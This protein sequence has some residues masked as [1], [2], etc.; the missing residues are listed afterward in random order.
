M[1][2]AIDGIA[3]NGGNTV[4]FYNRAD[5]DSAASG[6]IVVLA[7][8]YPAVAD[9]IATR[10][11]QL[12]DKII[13]DITNPLNFETFDSLVV[14][15]TVQLRRRERKCGRAT[16]RA[17]GTIRYGISLASRRL[18]ARRS[19]SASANASTK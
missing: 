1:G 14:P 3:T 12:A 10:G 11:D 2:Q 16:D 7:V 9:V 15:P 18:L 19:C 4:E 6:A 8:P 17:A 5:A 13:V